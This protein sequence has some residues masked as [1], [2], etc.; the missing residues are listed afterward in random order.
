MLKLVF[1][2]IGPEEFEGRWHVISI[3]GFGLVAIAVPLA[4]GA[5]ATLSALALEIFGLVFLLNGIV[6]FS[7][8]VTDALDRLVRTLGGIKAIALVLVGHLLVDA[9]LGTRT[10]PSLLF[11]RRLRD[12]RS[13]ERPRHK[14][15]AV[16]GILL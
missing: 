11:Q 6:T 16:T 10:G 4:A 15:T 8:A 2:L 7:G 14:L 3:P 1:L 13:N 5:S 9:T 12:I